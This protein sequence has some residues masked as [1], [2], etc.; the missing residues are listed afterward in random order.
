MPHSSQTR[1]APSRRDPTDSAGGPARQ[2]ARF[3]AVRPAVQIRPPRPF[4]DPLRSAFPPA[5]TIVPRIPAGV[6]GLLVDRGDSAHKK[7]TRPG[8]RPRPPSSGRGVDGIDNSVRVT[9]L[10]SGPRSRGRRPSALPHALTA[11]L[12]HPYDPPGWL[13]VASVKRAGTPAFFTPRS[14]PTRPIPDA[15]RPAN[16]LPPPDTARVRIWLTERP[17]LPSLPSGPPSLRVRWPSRRG[18]SVTTSTRNSCR[19]GRRLSAMLV[20]CSTVVPHAD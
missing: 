16:P 10:Q 20:C 7:N 15:C 3:G 18:P 9:P 11:P 17:S 6:V 13:V 8:R 5:R 12:P 19:I 14:S 4:I 1:P 2:S